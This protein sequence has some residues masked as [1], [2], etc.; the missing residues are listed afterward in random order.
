MSK[1]EIKE[2]K[3]KITEGEQHEEA[4]QNDFDACVKAQ[5]KADKEK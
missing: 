3:V 2:P 1:K 5:A 4:V